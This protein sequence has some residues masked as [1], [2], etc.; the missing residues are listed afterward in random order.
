MRI[1]IHPSRLLYTK[2]TI[3]L[4]IVDKYDDDVNCIALKALKPKVVWPKTRFELF[5]ENQT[6]SQRFHS[7]LYFYFHIAFD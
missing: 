3:D 1:K 2:S 7:K 6:T 4:P 5:F